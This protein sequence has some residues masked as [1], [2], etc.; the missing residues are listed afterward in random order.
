MVVL[1]ERNELFRTG[2][3]SRGPKKLNGRRRQFKGV[4]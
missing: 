3:W 1:I 4:A 2:G